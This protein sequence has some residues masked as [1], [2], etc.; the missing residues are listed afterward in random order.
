MHDI[1]DG[2]REGGSGE[3]EVLVCFPLFASPAAVPTS[4]AF[5]GDGAG[6]VA[7]ALDCAVRG[8]EGGRGGVGGEGWEV[9]GGGEGGRF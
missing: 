8:S 1:K 3:R 5:S 9:D 7:D 6:S 2:G 4:S